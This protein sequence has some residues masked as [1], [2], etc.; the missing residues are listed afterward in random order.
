M[1]CIVSLLIACLGIIPAKAVVKQ[2]DSYK[3][4]V[5]AGYLIMP[6]LVGRYDEAGYPPFKAGIAK[7]ITWCKENG[8]DYVPL[9]RWG[10]RPHTQERDA[11]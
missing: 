6:W 7:D 8:V 2:Y 5:M 10:S 9:A 11:A 4:L 1:K 3:E